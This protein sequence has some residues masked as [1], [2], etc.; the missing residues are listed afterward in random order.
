MSEILKKSG[1]T[2]TPHIGALKG[3][4]AKTVLLPGDP[5]RAK[6]IADNYLNDAKQVTSVRNILGF[7]GMY[8]GK[9]ISVMGTGMGMP[10]IGIYSYELFNFYDV[11]NLIRIGSA[12][13]IREDVKVMDIVLAEGAST[14]SAW[15]EMYNLKGTF[16]PIASWELLYK[17]V[18]TAER[19]G[20]KTV[21]GNILSEDAFYN[22][23]PDSYKEWQKMGIICLEMEAA[24]LYM[25]AA[26]CGKNALAMFTI[27]DNVLTGES[28]SAEERQVGFGKMM[29]LALEMQI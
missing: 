28:L 26:R 24:A 17:A 19:L 2:P 4:F 12:G 6:Y 10:S 18:K 13:S 23:D 25:N 3:D 20:S 27:S 15:A 29:E 7:T 21:V 14:T 16:A 9:E 8:K 5:L 1:N 11:D 22:D